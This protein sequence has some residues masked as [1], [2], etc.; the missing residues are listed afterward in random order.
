MKIVLQRVKNAEV[1]HK[2]ERVC[3][4]KEGLVLLVGFARNENGAVIGKMVRKIL[5]AK[6]FGKW[7]ASVVEMGYK[8]VVLSQFTLFGKLKGRKLD[9]HNAE[10]HERAKDLF[11][12][13]VK[14]FRAEYKNDMV[15]CGLFGEHLEIELVN[16]GPV[17]IVFDELGT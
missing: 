16:D 5:N 13:M 15:E 9:F 10:E 7:E 12:E 8:V 3:A 1:R 4:I 11:G 17:T 14:C 2:Q 6:V